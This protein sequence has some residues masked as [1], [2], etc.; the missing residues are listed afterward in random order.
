MSWA[1]T[2]L[3]SLLW[4][5]GPPD[6]GLLLP[7]DLLARVR[8]NR[9]RTLAVQYQHLDFR[10]VDLADPDVLVVDSSRDGSGAGEWTREEVAR[11]RTRPDGTSRIVLAYLSIGEAEDYRFYWSRKGPPPAFAGPENPRWPGNYRVRHWTPAWHLVIFGSPS[12]WVDRVVDRGFD[13]LFL[14]TVDSCE[15]WEQ[16]GRPGAC[17]EM[18]DL[19]RRLVRHGRSLRRDLV[20]VANN[21]FPI[22][23]L[24]GVRGALTGAMSENR[25]F[26][27][28]RMVRGQALDQVLS[29]LR[30]AR[31]AGLAILVLEYP[32]TVAGRRDLADLCRQEGFLCHASTPSLDQIGHILRPD[33]TPGEGR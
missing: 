17:A 10:R 16:E 7:G 20:V 19:V 15:V 12:S 13:G 33:T 3:P 28:G 27:G 21:P 18:A 23:D 5:L 2:L 30:E 9:A 11:L 29:P 8:M 31:Q 24:P 32:R 14:D 1:L 6:P 25:L 22:W 4:I 26:R